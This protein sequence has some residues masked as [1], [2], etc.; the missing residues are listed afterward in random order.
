MQASGM[1]ACSATAA[2]LGMLCLSGRSLATS[3]AAV[4]SDGMGRSLRSHQLGLIEMVGGVS[5]ATMSQEKA[6]M[7]PSIAAVSRR[8]RG[9]FIFP[10]RLGGGGSAL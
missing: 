9:F 10:I 7:W 1:R 4:C 3:E 2:A 5:P 6:T 8:R